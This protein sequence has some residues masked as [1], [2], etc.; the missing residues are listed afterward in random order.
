VAVDA[1][2]GEAEGAKTGGEIGAEVDAT[3]RQQPW[4]VA[5]D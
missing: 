5:S 3:I 2:S 4:V 1:G